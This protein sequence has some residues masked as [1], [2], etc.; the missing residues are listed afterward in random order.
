[1]TIETDWV[2]SLEVDDVLRAQGADPATIRTRRPALVT[3]AERALE[4]G[5]P[6]LQPKV[7]FARFTATGLRHER[8][9]LDGGALEGP[10]IAQHLGAAE[11]VIVMV[12]TI[13]D[14]LDAEIARQMDHDPVFALALDG[15][16]SA[17]AEALAGQA[18]N[19]FE[20]EAIGRAWRASLPLSPGMVG[21]PVQEGQAQIFALV[22]AGEAGVHLTEGGMMVPRKSLSL[23][24]G[25][26]SR[27]EAAGSACAYCT[28]HET[29]RY[30]GHFPPAAM[31]GS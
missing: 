11:Q 29:C 14:S 30:Q 1:M 21:W 27:L 4:A 7:A 9:T 31:Q 15:V 8:L 26:G 19:R 3:L 13:G 28:L 2:L 17:A 16:G 20:Q 23:V 5:Q 25:L 10:L 24:L 6:M 18:C 12:C 22:D